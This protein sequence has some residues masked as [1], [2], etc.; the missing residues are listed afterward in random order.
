MNCQNL[1]NLTDLL[2]IPF[3]LQ[4]FEMNRFFSIRYYSEVKCVYSFIFN[5][6]FSLFLVFFS[7]SITVAKRFFVLL[8]P[9]LIIILIKKFISL[10]AVLMVI[11][12]F[13]LLFK[14]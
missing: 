11:L 3:P 6:K 14:L 12:F 4:F 2:I 13:Y 7:F 1:L 9:D 10:L 8:T 5:I